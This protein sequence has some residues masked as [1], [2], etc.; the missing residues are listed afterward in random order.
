MSCEGAR[1]RVAVIVPQNRIWVWHYR[2]VSILQGAFKVDVYTSTDAP[3]YPLSLRLW[4]RLENYLFTKYDLVK[5]ATMSA[6]AWSQADSTVYAF[7][8]NLSEAPILSSNISVL[9][10]R[11]E[12]LADSLSLFAILLARKNPY[13]SF[14]AAGQDE[15]IAASYL[16]IQDRIVLSRGLQFSFA[17]LLMLADRTVHHLMRGTRAAL[18]PAPANVAPV[19]SKINVWLFF[20]RFLLDKSFGRFL[21]RFKFQEHWSI[22]LLQLG[23]WK[24]THDMLPRDIVMLP[25][26]GKQFYADPFLFTNNGQK[27]LFVEEYD[28]QVGKGVISCS[29]ITNG[30]KIH[31]PKQVLVRPYHLSY[32]FVFRYQDEIYMIPETGGNRTVE[33]FRARSFPFDWALSQVLLDNVEL[34]DATLLWHQGNWWI[35]G[36]I[37]HE[38]GSDQDE[39]AIFYSQSLEG[40]WKP[41]HL[42]PVKSD[43][44]SARPA[45]HV[46][47]CG[48]RLLRP[49]Q[50]CEAG[51]GCAIVWLEIEELTPDR[52][53]EREIARWPGNTVMNAEGIHT[54]NRDEELGVIDFRRTLWKWPFMA[55]RAR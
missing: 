1:Q 37:A 32:P 27:W 44:R 16:A 14:H 50:D 49:A 38:G 8:L 40:P 45:G 36:A 28:Y 18:L 42:N 6:T 31:P 13:I 41:H 51:Y 30:N 3:R 26:N 15:P 12:G 29:P 39:L 54:F 43:C 52:F 53:S 10:P 34:Y 2:I 33:L 21:R 35:F 24:L 55:I 25:D 7:I 5:F 47:N 22:A 23:Q 17:R 4:I 48:D 46:I 11:F 19:Y 20:V 9:E